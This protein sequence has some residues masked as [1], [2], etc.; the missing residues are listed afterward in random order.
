MASGHREHELREMSVPDNQLS[1][2]TAIDLSSLPGQREQ[3]WI[4]QQ[5]LVAIAFVCRGVIEARPRAH[6][7]LLTVTA[8]DITDGGRQREDI[9]MEA[10]ATIISY[11]RASGATLLAVSRCSSPRVWVLAH[12]SP[13]ARMGCCTSLLYGLAGANKNT[14]KAVLTRLC[15]AHG[16]RQSG[17]WST[18]GLHA[19]ADCCTDSRRPTDGRLDG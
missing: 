7:D 17:T 12:E 11:R 4:D 5:L 1:K 9:V 19:P 3:R 8:C 6:V 13:S 15:F 16:T 2:P 18:S 14:V 10:H